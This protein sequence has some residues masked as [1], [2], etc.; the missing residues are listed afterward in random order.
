[1]FVARARLTVVGVAREGSVD[2]AATIREQIRFYREVETYEGDV[3]DLAAAFL[4]EQV[5]GRCPVM[6]HCL[7]LASGSGSWTK[8]LL[9]SCERITA[10]D[11]SPERLAFSRARIADPRV[12]FIETDLFE[13]KPPA[14]YDLVF[15]GFW[16]SH[17]P[18]ARFDS[19]WAMVAD[20]LAPG[21]RVVMVDDGIRDASGV[22]HFETGP[23][24]SG[25]ERH[26][27]DGRAFSI[28]KVAHAPNEL[29]A[30]LGRLGWTATVTL[31]TRAIYVLEAHRRRVSERPLDAG[32]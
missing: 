21:G 18:P 30:S 3:G 14:R 16:L 7:E 22:E 32:R 4:S 11:S 1:L 9:G 19:F 27:A 12:E 20:A 5:L 15:A 13:F 26:L 2:D 24:G 29:I 28:V 31:L 25:A 23:D 6:S 17:V 8:Y 10:V